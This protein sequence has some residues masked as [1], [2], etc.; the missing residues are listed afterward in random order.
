MTCSRKFAEVAME[1]ASL[2]SFNSNPTEKAS[3]RE[4]HQRGLRLYAD[5]QYQEA[6]ALLQAAL[7][8]EATSERANDCAAAHLACGNRE[9]A[10]ADFLLAASLDAENMEAA[11]NLGILLASLARFREAIPYLQ[12]S[13]ARADASQRPALTQLLAL[14]GNN[15]AEHTLRASGAAEGR[16]IASRRLPAIPSQPA[17]AAT[18]R[19]PVYMGNNRALLC[20]T[21]H[22]KMY[23]DTTDL[24]IA[25]WLLMHGEWEPEETE[26]VKKLIKPGDVFVDAGANLGYYTLLAVRVG[27]SQVY[28]FE[29]RES[30]YEL[31]GKNVIIN[32]MS[33]VVRCEHLAVFSHTT[34]LEFFVRDSHPGNGRIGV[35][36]PD[37]LKKGSDTARKVTVHAV[38]LDDYF[39][40]KP[41]K[42][43][44]LKVDVE[45]AEPAVFQGARR[46]LTENRNIRVLCEWSPDQ[47]ATTQQNPETLVDLWA[48][49]GFRAFALHTGL[50]EV[51]LKSL[52]KGGY[53]NLLLHR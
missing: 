19:P 18:V 16:A 23:V 2:K 14:C 12:K 26:L 30:T 42:I 17:A 29:A 46:V 8:D 24:L 1:L 36:S 43:D 3:A 15:L 7:Q 44:L 52:L 53:Q 11:A 10:L 47:M 40:D 34:D 25:P 13:A 38:S 4:N 22:C 27:A 28:A 37:Q 20:T 51:S 33:S 41:G 49:L 9:K 5:R 45:G 35:S 50:G 6:A 48:E 39:A 31:L 32:W 21:N